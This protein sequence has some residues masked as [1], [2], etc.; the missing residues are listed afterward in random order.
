MK[1]CIFC[2][3]VIDE[4]DKHD[5][6]CA[7]CRRKMSLLKQI[8][9]VDKAAEKMRKAR[10]RYFY[11]QPEYS[12]ENDKYTI[13]RKIIENGIK[14]NS[15][16][17][18][19]VALEC[20]REKIRYLPNY[21]IGSYCVDFL[22]PDLKVIFEV[23]GELYHTNA[24]RD[25]IRERSIMSMVGEEYEIVR[26]GAEFIPN[27]ILLNFRES[28]KH[29][30]FQRNSSGH[31]RDTRYDTTYFREYLNLAGYLRRHR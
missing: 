26:L 3:T 13:S 1:E 27:Y 23:D 11:K 18:A 7:E 30:I 17:E 12:F 4:D 14:F 22:F 16:D 19:C 31:F 29:V 28:I 2:G 9:R 21:K 24:D 5:Y 8:D 6:A 20:E 15:V 10:K 25:F